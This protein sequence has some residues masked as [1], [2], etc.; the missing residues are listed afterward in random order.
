MADLPLALALAAGLV[1]AFNPCG[2]A[3]LP[4]YL[5]ALIA[6]PAPAEGPGGSRTAEAGGSRTAASGT[7]GA[8]GRAV[9]LSVAMTAG[10][11]TVFGAF[12]L[13][14]TP[15]AVSV[16]EYLPWVTIAIGVGLTAV[17]GWLVSGRELLFRTPKMSTG[18]V[19]MSPLSLYGYGLSYAVA[20][21]SCTVGPFLAVVSASL[22]SGGVLGGL[23]V[24]VAYAVGM[25]LVVALLSVAVALARASLAARMRRALPYVSRVSGGLLLAAGVYVVYYGWYELRVFAGAA[26]DDPVVGAVTAAQGAVSRAVQGAGAGWI[27]GALLAL[28]V[29]SAL[30]TRRVRAARRRASGTPDRPA[31]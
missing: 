2:F 16:G 3:L 29:I 10:F 21:L 1:A 30:L 15:L 11:V 4:A 26:A 5:T 23:A 31:A 13:V 8:V 6:D 25:G 24:F 9:R 19:T 14:V 12:G 28:V 18:R 20:S 17:G 7:G 27:A 22:T